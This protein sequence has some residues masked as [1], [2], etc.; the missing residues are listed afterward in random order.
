MNNTPV[1]RMGKKKLIFVVDD[2]PD[3]NELVCNVLADAGYDTISAFDGKQAL[4]MVREHQPDLVLLDIM[5]P[6]I[7]GVEVCRTINKDESIRTIPVIMVTVKTGLSSKLSS[8]V[9]GARRYITKP[10]EMD[11]LISEVDKVLK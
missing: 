3:M 1:S 2:D 8:Y 11:E 10:I 7:D 6:E 4:E 5:L 9:A